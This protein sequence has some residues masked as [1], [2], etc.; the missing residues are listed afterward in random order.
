MAGISFALRRGCF[1]GFLAR[2]GAGK[3]TTIKM[4][5]G[6]LRPSGGRAFIDGLALDERLLEIKQRIGVLP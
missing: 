5:T 2:M 6:Q 3:S 1:F 4:L